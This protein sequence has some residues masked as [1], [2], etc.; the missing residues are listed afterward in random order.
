MWTQ[1]FIA[2]LFNTAPKWEQLKYLSVDEQDEVH[3]DDKIL[4]SQ[5]RN[6]VIPYTVDEPWKFYAKKNKLDS[7][8]R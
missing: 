5:R 7:K 6:E 1:V 3:P 8:G 2:V 4:C